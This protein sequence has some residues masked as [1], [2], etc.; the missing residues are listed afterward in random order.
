MESNLDKL[1][2]KKIDSNY[3]L[4]LKTHY[5]FSFLNIIHSLFI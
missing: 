1:E 2:K 4:L 5:E 3:S